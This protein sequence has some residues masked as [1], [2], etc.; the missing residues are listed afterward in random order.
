MPLYAAILTYTDDNERI[1]NIRPTHREYLKS[2]LEQGKLVQSGPFTDDSGA[3]IVY[4]AEDISEAQVLLT[5]D[6]FAMNGVIVGAD[7]KEWN[8]VMRRDDE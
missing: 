6:P 2:L 8:I 4:E 7:L 3:L 1:Q 5:N